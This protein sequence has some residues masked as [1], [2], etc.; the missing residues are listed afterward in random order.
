MFYQ[1]LPMQTQNIH[2]VAKKYTVPTKYAKKYEFE[3][4]MSLPKQG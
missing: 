2:F 1:Y 4:M 3:K